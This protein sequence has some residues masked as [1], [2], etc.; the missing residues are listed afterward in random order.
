MPPQELTYGNPKQRQYTS[1][2]LHGR[3][4]NSYDIGKRSNQFNYIYDDDKLNT[5]YDF[6]FAPSTPTSR[7]ARLNTYSDGTPIEGELANLSLVDL[8]LSMANQQQQTKPGGDFIT[9]LFK[10]QSTLPI[11]NLI[12]YFDAEK[13][14]ATEPGDAE[15][16]SIITKNLRKIEK[17]K[18]SLTDKGLLKVFDESILE[19]AKAAEPAAEVKSAEPGVKIND[20]LEKFDWKEQETFFEQDNIAEVRSGLSDITQA[21]IADFDN[22]LQYNPDDIIKYYTLLNKTY[23]EK[24]KKDLSGNKGAYDHKIKQV[25]R[26]FKYVLDKI[27]NPIDN[28]ISK[29]EIK[30]ISK[31]TSKKEFTKIGLGKYWDVDNVNPADYIPEYTPEEKAAEQ[32]KIDDIYGKKIDDIV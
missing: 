11:N 12:E 6:R 5:L 20:V 15:L 19:E 3:K 4:V 9:N 14:M 32:Q 17:F 24:A 27:Q 26:I 18:K 10:N 25:K 16:L 7:L 21:F 2:D 13:K 1:G 28:P 23:P 8:Q 29:K 31:F 30:L 22:I